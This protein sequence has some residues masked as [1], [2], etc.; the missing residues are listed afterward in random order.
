[1]QLACAPH[2]FEVATNAKDAVVAFRDAYGVRPLALGKLAL[3]GGRGVFP[4][5]TV[6]DFPEFDNIPPPLDVAESH[7]GQTV[8]LGL[9]LRS[10]NLP[11]VA[12][13]RSNAIVHGVRSGPAGCGA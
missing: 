10:G 3:R 1:M 4:D 5:G 2:L 11:D 6:F 9:P 12:R 13:G 7:R 8:Y